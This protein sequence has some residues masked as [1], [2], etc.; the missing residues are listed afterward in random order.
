ME[1]KEKIEESAPFNMALK[2][3]ERIND[4]LKEYNE[5]SSQGFSFVLMCKMKCNKCKEIYLSSSA[6]ITKDKIKKEI[7]KALLELEKEFTTRVNPNRIICNSN[8]ENKIDNCVENIQDALQAEKYF[9]PPKGD[10][11]FGWKES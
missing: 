6:L 11:R 4:L 3:L 9:M 5:L 2:T 8:T 10:P 1:N 7:K